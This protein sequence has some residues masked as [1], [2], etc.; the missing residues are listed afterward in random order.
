MYTAF[1]KHTSFSASPAQKNKHEFCI[2]HYAGIVVYSSES[3]LEKNKDETPSDAIDVCCISKNKLL[4]KLFMN[5]E[6]FPS[7]ES[8]STTTP[9]R[10]KSSS[11][12]TLSVC[13]QFK[14]QLTSLINTIKTT[15]PHYVRCIKPN[16]TSSTGVFD[17]MKCAEQLRNGGILSAVQ[18]CKSGFQYRYSHIEFYSRYRPIAN[19]T[20]Q[21]ASDLPKHIYSAQTSKSGQFCTRLWQALIDESESTTPIS[22]KLKKQ[23]EFWR[24]GSSASLDAHG[25]QVGKTIVFMKDQIYDFLEARITKF[26]N[27]FI[28]RIQALMKGVLFRRKYMRYKRVILVLQTRFR[29]RCARKIYQSL[30]LNHKAFVLQRAMRFLCSRHRLMRFRKAVIAVQSKLRKMKAEETLRWLRFLKEDCY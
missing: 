16:D 22:R 23:I 24:V 29:C 5:D 4:V 2:Q 26:M 8:S 12:N 7:N 17:R 19:M 21:R 6:I 25:L 11:Q 20:K 27:V 28:T 13:S 14:E 10:R 1:D 9:D 15:S 18:V 30:K 3:F